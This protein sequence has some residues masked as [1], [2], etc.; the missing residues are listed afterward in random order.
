MKITVATLLPSLR[1]NWFL[2]YNKTQ[3]NKRKQ[4]Q[5]KKNNTNKDQKMLYIVPTMESSVCA[6]VYVY[7]WEKGGMY[8]EILLMNAI[9]DISNSVW[10]SKSKSHIVHCSEMYTDNT[11]VRY[12]T[13]LV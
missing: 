7:V 5:Q 6:C 13:K 10:L 11:A 12:R 3:T 9:D 2:T 8:F 1:I 4:Q